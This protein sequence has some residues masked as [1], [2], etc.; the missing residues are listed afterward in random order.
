MKFFNEALK[1]NLWFGLMATTSKIAPRHVRLTLMYLYISVHLIFT[2]TVFQFE[3]AN[4]I[5]NF[6]PIAMALIG[7]QAILPL[8]FAWI[9]GIPVA[10]IFRMPMSVRK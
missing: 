7:I 6:I 8:M 5:Q 3:L 4:Y 2:T 10:L 9:I 1:T